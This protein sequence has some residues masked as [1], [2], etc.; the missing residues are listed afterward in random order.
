MIYNEMNQHPLARFL[1]ETEFDA[2]RVISETVEYSSEDL[3]ISINAR[4][5][6]IMCLD[7]GSAS[8][9]I[10]SMEGES[11]EVATLSEGSLIGEMNFVVP[12]RRTANVVANCNLTVTVYPYKKLT[13]LLKREPLIAA[14][15]FAAI[16]LSLADKYLGMNRL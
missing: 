14:K 6:D 7:Q 15:I 13:E 5:R 8:V 1:T 4:N 12:T 10:E 16:N 3:I 2:L 9:R 11:I